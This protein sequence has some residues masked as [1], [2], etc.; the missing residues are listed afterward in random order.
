VAY[1]G[2]QDC[3][4]AIL[5]REGGKSDIPINKS[6]NEWDCTALLKA[7][8]YS[9]TFGLVTCKST[10]TLYHQYLKGKK[11]SPFHSVISPTGNPDET[12]TL[13][14]D[15][16]RLLRNTLCHIPKPTISKVDINYYIQLAKDAFTATGVSV[17]GI[18]DIGCLKEEDFPTA[19]VNELSDGMKTELQETNKFLQQEVMEEISG[20]KNAQEEVMEKISG[21]KYA[22]ATFL[23]DID[24][25]LEGVKMD[26]IGQASKN[27]N[28]TIFL[29]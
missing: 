16:L 22:Q 17:V 12:V 28:C 21:F 6:I 2:Q 9:N 8:I 15:Q 4:I 13:A 3:H 1:V 29:F 20:F 10:K 14:I 7:T 26:I 5:T 25:K 24:G 23:H 18:D 11:P 19:K 27:G